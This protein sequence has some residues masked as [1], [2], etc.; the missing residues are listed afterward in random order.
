MSILF[1][2]LSLEKTAYVSNHLLNNNFLSSKDTNEN[3]YRIN[4]VMSRIYFKI[5]QE[6]RGE[7]VGG[8]ISR[9]RLIILK[10]G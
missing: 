7:R 1:T 3:V 8:H 6:G 9:T 2:T 4:N 5:V 10:A